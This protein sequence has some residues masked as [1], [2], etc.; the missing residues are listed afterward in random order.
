MSDETNDLRARLDRERAKIGNTAF[1]KPAT[2][3]TNGKDDNEILRLAKLST[4]H[5]D[6]E[7]EAS[8]EKLGV[9]IATLDSAVKAERS[10]IT[11][12]QTDFL[13]H[14]NNEPWPE[15]VDGAVLLNRLRG[16]FLR[17]VVLPKH[18]D[19]A[20]ALWA[21]RTWVF[22]CFDVTPYLAITSPTRRCG[23]TVLMTI[24][25]WLCRRAKKNDHMSKASIYR[26]V[27][28]EQPTLILDEVGW[29]VDMKDERQG[30][31]CGGFE[32]L[33][34][35]EICE[36]EGADIITKRYSTYCPK[37][38]GLI[39]KLT[40]TL[41]DRSIDIRM[42]RKGKGDKVERLRRRDNPDH[43]EFRRQCLR[44]ADD[45]REALATIAPKE[46]AGLNDRAFDAWEP[47]LAI[48]ECVGG[49]WPKLA[50]EAARAL[51]GGESAGEERGVEVLAGIR[52]E[53]DACAKP[54]I[55]T[56]T[57]IKALCTDDEKP[58][59]TYDK[60]RPIT[61]RLLAKLLKPFEIV[62]E[63]V[64]TSETGEAKAKGYRRAHFED[65]F[66]RYLTP[67][68]GGQNDATRQIEGARACERANAD[69]TG[70]SAAFCKR[71][72]NNLHGNEKCKKPA[73]DEGLHAC[74][75]RNPQPD[76]K[77][78]SGHPIGASRPFRSDV[79]DDLTIPKSLDRRGEICAQ[80]GR[81]GTVTEVWFGD[82]QAFVHP[83]C[84]DA[85]R[86]AQDAVFNQRSRLDAGSSL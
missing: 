36:G 56:K 5:Y 16:H 24:L 10:K 50:I 86:A 34:F 54:A 6:K 9:R 31:L 59:A 51:S 81:P 63:T 17:H 68:D 35:V 22:N 47:L 48:A 75:L 38:F 46:P 60:G 66:S 44:W 43:Q 85:W 62:S 33:G 71:A 39:G 73:N 23:K 70:T 32:R 19:V 77:H 82:R 4:I 78:Q 76:D 28:A 69:E 2:N 12:E 53:F 49:D 21:L 40:P 26:S 41:M 13:P 58:W 42:Q 45:N 55:T 30:I 83:H 14:W 25:Y 27:E 37:A 18:A 65:A 84:R 57:L 74:T 64:Q 52:A 15:R 61:D 72:E 1:N 80:C 79:E 67:P 20:L 29:V 3:A 8:A 7:R 11:K